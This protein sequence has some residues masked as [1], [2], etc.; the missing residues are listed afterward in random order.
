ALEE[1]L[2]Y[3]QTRIQGG[4]PIISHQAVKL[5]LF[6][7]F[8]S[9]EAAR[10]LARRVAV[11]NTALANNMQIPAV[12]YS[13]ASKIMATETAF[14]V[15]SQAIQLHGGYGLSKEYVIEKIFRDARASLIEDGANDVL[16]LDG[17]KRLM[18]GKTTWVAVEG[19]VQPGA[20]AGAEPPSYE[21]LKP[22]FRPTGVHMGIMTADPD[23]CT[24]CGLCLQNCPFRAWETDDRG[25]PKMKAEYECFSC[26]NCMVVCPVDAISIVDGYHVDEGVYRTD[27]LP[28][29]LAPP[30]QA[31]DAD[32]APTEW[33]AQERMIFERRSVRNF[34]PDPVPESYIRRIVEAGR[35]APS[36]GNCQPWKFI[37]VT[38]KDLITQMDQ[39][40]FNILT[41]MHNT[42]KNDAM[43]RAL[44]P[45]FMETQSV[46]LFDPRI[47]LGGMGSI[48]KQYAP[49]FLNA[50]CVILVACDDRAIGGPQISA[51][52]CGQNMNLV[53]KSLGLGFCWNG[54]SQVIEMDPSMKEKLGLKEPWKINT[55]MSIGFPKFKQEG[56]VPRERRPVTWFRE[57][58]E[59]PEVEG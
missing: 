14:R 39:S 7:M 49:P 12:H 4:R 15:A 40:V 5:R 8:V 33:N 58:V 16:A 6:D 27:P 56:I 41:M 10:S 28:L 3:T 59:G 25:Y 22:M 26:F 21:E 30:L 57:G 29:P 47:I 32:G 43:A 52:I 18:E 35:F 53:A 19:L 20:A 23:K 38:S 55:A 9:V 2:S 46:G 31:M 24:Q 11:Y 37:V 54:F 48:A 45:V 36:G 34:K 17:A 42:Y 51:G 1:A 44:I 13:M 50:P